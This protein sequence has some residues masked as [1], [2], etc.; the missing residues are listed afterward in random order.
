MKPSLIICSY[1][2]PEQLKCCLAGVDAE[3]LMKHQGELILVYMI[4]DKAS[5]EVM[6][7]YAATAPFLVK[8]I[9]TDRLGLSIARNAGMSI[10]EGEVLLWTDDDCVMTPQY[11]DKVIAGM[12]SGNY[13][14]G[15]GS[16]HDPNHH[17]AGEGH[18]RS[19]MTI[20]PKSLLRAGIISGSSMFFRKEVFDRIG[21]F[22]VDMGAGSGMPY[23]GA[24]DLEMVTRASFADY[25]GILLSD[26][27]IIHNHNRPLGSAAEK[28]TRRS[29]DIMRGSHYAYLISHGIHDG[30]KLWS[31]TA[32]P[33]E[34]RR[35]H[36][37]TL[38]RLKEEFDGAAKYLEHILADNSSSETAISTDNKIK[39]AN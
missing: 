7:N 5:A 21:V 11:I 8:T 39:K 37:A 12:R 10:A 35:V 13:G 30:W 26:A 34:D 27:V 19:P 24:E 16:V 23:I 31:A 20:A 32:I 15:G 17:A 29:Y 2:R 36:R 9:P 25:A 28:A 3:G 1:G 38:E 14:F 18:I 6:Q 33:N 22:R 4:E